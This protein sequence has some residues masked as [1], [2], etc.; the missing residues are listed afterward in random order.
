MR[1]GRK[2]RARAFAVYIIAPILIVVEISALLN[3]YLCPKVF[4]AVLVP[5]V[6]ALKE[7][8]SRSIRRFGPDLVASESQ[9]P[10][11][12]YETRVK[13]RLDDLK[14]LEDVSFYILVGVT[15][16]VALLKALIGGE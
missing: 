16:A 4:L 8:F 12:D 14:F 13:A 6:G 3:A 9:Y 15:T 11:E 2:I 1:K 5:T 7:A 10:G